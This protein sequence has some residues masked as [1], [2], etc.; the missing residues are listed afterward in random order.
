MRRL[1][2]RESVL[3]NVIVLGILTTLAGVSLAEA[4]KRFMC[5]NK[6]DLELTNVAVASY[7]QYVHKGR[8][9]D[10][11]TTRQSV[12]K[13][14]DGL[15]FEGA[16]SR[17]DFGFDIVE[18]ELFD[19]KNGARASNKDVKKVAVFVTDGF[20]TRGVEFTRAS[21]DTL[22]REG[23]NLFSVGISDHVDKDEL[24]E[25]ASKPRASHQLL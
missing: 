13:A 5:H 17:L 8:T 14:I 18:F 10:D 22:T 25:L 12:L 4:E 16:A 23:V 24:D 7:S 9:F 11:D 1:V 15:R 19:T 2:N 6:I 3:M 20:S 21:A